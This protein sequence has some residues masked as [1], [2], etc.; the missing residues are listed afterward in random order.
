MFHKKDYTN[1]MNVIL[2]GEYDECVGINILKEPVKG[3]T[4][5][6]CEY[7][8]GNNKIVVDCMVKLDIP[9]GATT[10]RPYNSF[11][12]ITN[13]ESVDH[14]AYTNKANVEE[15]KLL[16][17]YKK[18]PQLVGKYPDAMHYI[19]KKGDKMLCETFNGNK[20][21]RE[22]AGTNGKSLTNFS[23]NALFWNTNNHVGYYDHKGIRFNKFLYIPKGYD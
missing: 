22:L 9:V 14:Y 7:G 4:K 2:H 16:E 1:D 8:H 20:L 13:G 23:G 18:Y 19:T 10:V 3:I 15:V 6:L 21:E 11:I 17:G 12:A 5:M